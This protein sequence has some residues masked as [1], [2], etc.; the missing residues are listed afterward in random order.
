MRFSTANK[1]LGDPD[2]LELAWVDRRDDARILAERGRT[3]LAIACGI[4]ALEIKLKTII[5]R[6]LDLERSPKEFEIHDLQGLLTVAGL[7]RKINAHP[8]IKLQW[9]RVVETAR[10]LND[11]RYRPNHS[12]SIEQMTEFFFSL[13][14]PA[15]G[16][17]PWLSTL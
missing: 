17:L 11:F 7:S 3:G 6:K 12:F 8:L 4:Y 13:E 9:V 16:V 5:C 2:E 10:E 1:D 15:E 14:D